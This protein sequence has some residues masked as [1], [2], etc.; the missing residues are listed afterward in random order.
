M[1]QTIRFMSLLSDMGAEGS[2]L[3][4]TAPRYIDSST[5]TLVYGDGVMVRFGQRWERRG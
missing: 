3:T 1:V 2:G 4:R 5:M